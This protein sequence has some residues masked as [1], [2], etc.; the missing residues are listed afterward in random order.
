MKVAPVLTA[1]RSVGPLWLAKADDSGDGKS[2]H[3]RL[4]KAHEFLYDD[5]LFALEHDGQPLEPDHGWPV[6]L[7]VPRLYF[8]KSAKWV[9]GIELM[10][11]DTAGFWEQNGYHR[12]GDPWTEERHSWD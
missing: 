1:Q 9:R 4:L 10:D 5:C 2:G 3:A 6:R 12:H 11:K 7:V 8:W